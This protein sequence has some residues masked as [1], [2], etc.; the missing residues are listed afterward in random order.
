M[1]LTVT[2]E[3]NSV[4]EFQ[5]L[6]R[7]LQP[8]ENTATQA[9]SR[10]AGGNGKAPDHSSAAKADLAKQAQDAIRKS[11][12][13]ANAGT[14]V[15]AK[16]APRKKADEPAPAPTQAP[17]A[18]PTGELQALKDLVTTAARLAMRG[19][20]D[21]KILDLLPAFRDATGL[22]FVMNATEAHIPALLQLAQA[23]NLVTV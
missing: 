5:W 22:D 17:A 10:P 23:A 7:R 21:K 13:A 20:G 2:I 6:A 15:P 16:K 1:K 19:E 11:E 4:N 14:P 9:E 3:C 8:D 12:A 18:D